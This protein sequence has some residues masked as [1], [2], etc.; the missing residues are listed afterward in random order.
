MSKQGTLF[1]K[2]RHNRDKG[3]V[4]LYLGKSDKE[5]MQAAGLNYSPAN[6]RR[7]RC[8]ADVRARLKELFDADRPFLFLEA[9]RARREREALAYA[10]MGSYF[11][12]VLDEHGKATGAVKFKGFTNLTDEQIAAIASFKPTKL[13][14][15]LKLHDKDSSLK[16]IEQRVE[17]QVLPTNGLDDQHIERDEPQCFSGST[18]RTLVEPTRPN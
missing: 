13:G 18:L 15:E 9:L 7:F 5:A 4:A 1:T 10:R 11:E 16:A 2:I 12:D 6:G 8:S 14:F 17:P 3:A